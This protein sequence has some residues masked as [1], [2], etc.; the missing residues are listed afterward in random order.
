MGGAG[1]RIDF[2]KLVNYVMLNC[3]DY[4]FVRMV[5]KLICI[6]YYFRRRY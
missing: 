4:C 1:A 5:S 3:G 2:I 6:D